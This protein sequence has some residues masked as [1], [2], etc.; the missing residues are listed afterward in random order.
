MPKF[1][2]RHYEAVARLLAAHRPAVD[3]NEAMILSQK[4]DAIIE[5]FAAMFADDNPRFNRSTFFK[6]CDCADYSKEGE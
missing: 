2:K 3:D 1:A 4:V 5:D 6:A